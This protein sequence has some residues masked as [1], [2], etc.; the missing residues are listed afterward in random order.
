ME[1][2]IIVTF[3]IEKMTLEERETLAQRAFEEFSCL[4]QHFFDLDESCVEAFLGER[5][6]SGGLIPE[7]I[8]CEVESRAEALQ[9]EMS[10][11][12]TKDNGLSFVKEFRDRFDIKVENIQD[13]DWNEVWRSSFQTIAVSSDLKIV[14]E[15]KKKKHRKGEVYIYP[16][17]G[18]GTGAHETTFLC[19]K[20][21]DKLKKQGLL[22][23]KKT[24]LD[25]GCGSGILGITAIKQNSMEVD[26]V[27]VDPDALDN[28][29]Y[30]LRVNKY[31]NYSQNH[32]LILR[33]RFKTK[34]YDLVFANILEHVLLEEAFLLLESLKPNSFLII[35]GLLH[36]QKQSIKQCYLELELID[37]LNEGEWCSLCFRRKG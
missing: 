23:G 32:S 14:P 9:K 16:G 18:F 6:Y 36:N 30:N 25:F 31:Q 11:Y 2:A 37:D 22:K 26:F 19:L 28:C 4:G 29:L 13:R 8:L 10:F 3:N 35:S 7:D 33:E 20:M 5:S 21:F 24:C 15:W 34:P 12:F 27:D 17:M 1:Q